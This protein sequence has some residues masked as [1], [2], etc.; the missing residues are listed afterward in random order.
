[1][2]R[3]AFP[4][5]R[6]E[7]VEQIADGDRVATRK[8]FH[9]THRGAFAGIAPTGREVTIAVMDIVRIGEGQIREHWNVVDVSG[10]MRQL[11]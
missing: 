5:L 6:A 10:L 4:D 7:V 11:A 8:I 2:L 9:G 1:V 3:A